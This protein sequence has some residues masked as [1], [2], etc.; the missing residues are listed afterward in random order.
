[1]DTAIAPHDPRRLRT[2][3]FLTFGAKVLV[4]GLQAV[5]TVVVARSLGPGGR[6]VFYVALGL[7]LILAQLGTIGLGVANTYVAAQAHANARRLTWI[8]LF[9]A[10]CIGSI[11]IFGG[12]AL[13]ELFPDALPNLT[14]TDLSLALAAVP[15]ALA[16]VYLQGILV[17]LGR[18]VPYNAVEVVQALGTLVGLVIGFKL[19]GFGPTG[20]LAVMVAGFYFAGLTY[21]AILL[22]IS[23]PSPRGAASTS[24]LRRMVVFSLKIYGASLCMF[25]LLRLDTLLVNAYLGKDEAGYYSAATAVADAV[26]VLPVVIGLNLLPRIARDGG[27]KPTAEIFSGVALIYGLVCLISVLLAGPGIELLFGTAFEPA[28][29]LYYWLAPGVFC[30]GMTSILANHFA[31]RGMPLAAVLIWVPGLV[32]NVGLNIAFLESEG[33]YVASL[34]SSIGYA[35]VLGLAVVLFARE[36]GSAGPLQPSVTGAVRLVRVALSR[37]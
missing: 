9:A 18:M 16:A 14:A 33:T 4:M 3:V 27:W 20:G 19:L 29:S 15:A 35:V 23:P 5:A 37:G 26:M 31:G 1:M 36:A 28:V 11:L 13:H 8:S 24:A 34:A 25:L 30:L 17:G 12:F 32:L 21:A 7:T 22:V 10:A 6:G 2:D